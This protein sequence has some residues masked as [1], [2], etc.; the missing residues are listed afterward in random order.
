VFFVNSAALDEFT[1]AASRLTGSADL[2]VHAAGGGFADDV[3]A[4]LAHD[5]DVETASAVLEIDAAIPG[6]REPLRILGLDPLRAAALQP[7]LLADVAPHLLELLHRDAL[8]LSPGAAA[9]A[10]VKVGDALMVTVGSTRKRLRVI[11]LL[12]EEA[13]PEPLGIMDIA[14]AQLTFERLGRLD[15]I[16]L[17]LRPGTDLT[18]FR[19]ALQSRLPAGV[20]LILPQTERERP[21]TLTRAYRV[22][23]NML[24]LVSLW[25]GAF[26]VFSTEALAVLR[27][28]RALALLRALGITRAQLQGALTCEGAAI[29][30]LGSIIGLALG[31]LVALGL[32]R[33]L[34]GD[35]GNG[36]LHAS[37]GRLHAAPSSVCAFL[38]IGTLVAAF[39]AWWPARLA[40]REAPARGLKGGDTA[41]TQFARRGALGGLALLL[42]GALCT[43]LP[44]LAGLPVF[45]YAGIA[46]LLLGAV[47]LVPLPTVRLLAAVPR[48]RRV[49]IDTALAQLR[50]NVAV[51]TLSLSAILVSFSLMVAMAIMVYSFRVSFE[52]WLDRLL[53]ADLQMRE[54]QGSDTARWSEADQH[55][56][57]S[58]PG[59]ARLEPRRTRPLLLAADRPPVTL[60]A[61]GTSAT[62]LERA[63]PVMRRAARPATEMSAPVWIS[64]AIADLYRLAPGDTLSLPLGD[65]SRVVTVAG[66]WRDYAR[67]FGALVMARP[68]Y[69]AL[70]GDR[71][72]NEAAVWLSPGA[73]AA[74]V[75]Q[76]L[77]ACLAASGSVEVLSS[78]AIR[79]RSLRI[80]D[81]AFA[82]TYALEA[83]AVLIGLA[84]V[85]FAASSNALAR[86]AEFGVLRHIGWQ[87][88]QVVGLLATEGI[89]MSL[90]GA[91]YGVAV[92]LVLSRVLIDVVNR[93]S[94]HWSIDFH[95]PWRELALLSGVLIAAAALTA[96]LSGSAALKAEAVRAVREDW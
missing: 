46:A 19:T 6:S 43:R 59:V 22:N 61:R 91:L 34:A 50:D 47:A 20:L 93:Q 66:I 80:F 31:A 15:R 78:V 8:L 70:S 26:L 2:I 53:P 4:M 56:L 87:R 32:L 67:S 29:G 86:R 82:I 55:C 21:L 38:A 60:I 45:G 58:V 25:T 41:H 63:L 72:A 12:S 51:S 36:Q 49:V 96:V 28:R 39:G 64:E 94:F 9:R 42:L 68:Q 11:G 16:D 79:E 62:E 7:T 10:G 35:L 71:S 74:S 40:A 95:A 44:A 77:K 81:R 33:W 5:P 84:G 14:A 18:A 13:Y 23:L 3:Y 54:P 83:I 89:A 1:L 88:R 69:I 30:A 85:S 48:S 90:L 52:H 73:S 76:G 24:A 27:Q 57:A 17:R 37:G 92:G 65:A 75:T